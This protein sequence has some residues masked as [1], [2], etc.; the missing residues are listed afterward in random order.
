MER[1]NRHG[2][3]EVSHL[4]KILNISPT[5]LRRDLQ[6]LEERK[7]LIRTYGGAISNEESKARYSFARAE[8]EHKEEKR[9]IGV[10][11]ANM[12]KEGDTVILGPGTTTME[13]ARNVKDKQK[14]VMITDSIDIAYELEGNSN[15]TVILTGGVLRE[16]SHSL[17]GHVVEQVLGQMYADKLFLPV[18][19]ITISEGA[20]NLD[21]FTVSVKKAMIS[22][23]REVIVVADSSKIGKR[24]LVP[25]TP[26]S[27]INKI[28]TDDN[29]PPKEI[30]AFQR[31]GIEVI[32]C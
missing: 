8:V 28:I 25:L 3:V 24:N 19:G 27:A 4:S 2:F 6:K 21:M 13:I 16:E 20:T 1:V 17:V 5:T 30:E 11:A 7:L 14:L 12:I 15:I 23:A 18:A 9:K 26:L 32:V 22:T 10:V 29:A 31:K